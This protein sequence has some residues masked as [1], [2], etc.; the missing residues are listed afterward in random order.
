[1]PIEIDDEST[2]F[3]P[4]P[5]GAQQRLLPRGNF[6][7]QRI[8]G[9][10]QETSIPQI[11]SLPALA[12]Q[13]PRKPRMTTAPANMPV[14]APPRMPVGTPAVAMPIAP[15]PDVFAHGSNVAP[16]PIAPMHLAPEPMSMPP[17]AM[18]M[19]FSPTIAATM[20][21]FTAPVD[22][23]YRVHRA[24]WTARSFVAVPVGALAA[25]LLIVIGYRVSSVNMPRGTG[26]VPMPA[27][28]LTAKP[29]AAPVLS[30][31][32]YVPPVAEGVA[33]FEAPAAVEPTL[34]PAPIQAEIAPARSHKASR[35]SSRATTTAG[36]KRPRKIV[37]VDASTPLGNLRVKRY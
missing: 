32:A 2:Q 13:A 35:K 1:M 5:W 11:P 31:D 9:T 33:T 30:P 12:M 16:L 28:A 20:P 25:I 22:S 15:P 36:K 8:S 21:V 27:A 37:A 23:T 24:R 34:A 7:A 18:P 19:M 6:T 10:L 17:A 3:D 14:A 4:R 29:I 26:K